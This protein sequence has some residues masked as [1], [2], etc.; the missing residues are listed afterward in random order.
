MKACTFAG[1]VGIARRSPGRRL[2]AVSALGVLLLAACTGNGSLAEA[3]TPPAA[4]AETLKAG[5]M[6]FFQCI[7]CHTTGPGEP[8]MQGQNLAGVFGKE[9]GA[10]PGFPYSDALVNSGVTWTPETMD[11][12]LRKPSEFIP[13]NIM[14]YVGMPKAEDRA[15]LVAYLKAATAE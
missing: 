9:A 10:K 8:D 3:D 7:A 6:L 15:A 4:D 1:G 14:A 12:W 13:G 5:E 11:E 2:A